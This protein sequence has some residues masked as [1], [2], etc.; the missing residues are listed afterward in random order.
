MP[1]E[2]EDVQEEARLFY[3]AATRVT[4]KL[5]VTISGDTEF[6]LRRLGEKPVTALSARDA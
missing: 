2:S 6:G 3:V 5:I 1:G 4:H